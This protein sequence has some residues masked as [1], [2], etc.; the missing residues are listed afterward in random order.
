MTLTSEDPARLVLATTATDVGQATV[1]VFVPNGTTSFSYYLQGIEGA[2][3]P[4]TLTVTSPLFTTDTATISVNPT[5]L[6]II[7]LDRKSVV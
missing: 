1:Q 6:R 7:Q 4:A 5:R 3:G 2:T